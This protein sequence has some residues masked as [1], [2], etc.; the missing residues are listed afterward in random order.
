[1]STLNSH[2]K[3]LI[4][5][6]RGMVGSSAVRILTENEQLKVIESSRSLLTYFH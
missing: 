1:M 4:L 2:K 6:S 3:I 5:G